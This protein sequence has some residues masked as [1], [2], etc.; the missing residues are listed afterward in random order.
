LHTQKIFDAT[1]IAYP[2]QLVA[3]AAISTVLGKRSES[4]QVR[5]QLRHWLWSGMFGEVYTRGHEVRAAHDVLEVPLWLEGGS[6]PTTMS[7]ANFSASRLFSVRKRFGAVYQGLSAL[8]RLSGAIDWSTG[9]EINDVLYFEQRIE[10]HHIFPVAWCKKQG[11]DP[12]YYNCLVNRTP[13]SAKTNKRIGSKSPSVYLKQ[14]EKEGI[15]PTRLDEMLHSH[16]INPMM[17]RRD[18]FEGFFTTRTKALMEIISKAM[19][20]CLTVEAFGAVGEDY[21]NGNGNGL[22]QLIN[23]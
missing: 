21:N 23:D 4:E 5:S 9:E 16:A 17:L 2:I 12:K 6:L 7:C 10:S 1:D 14:F 19:A 15:A 3:L 20:K 11:I 22:Q 18:D 8:L 13:L